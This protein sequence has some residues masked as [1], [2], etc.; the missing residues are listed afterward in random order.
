MI[1][2]SATFRWKTKQT[3]W[4]DP[5]I[6]FKNS[7]ERSLPASYKNIKCMSIAFQIFPLD[8]HI[9]GPLARCTRGLAEVR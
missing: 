9:V 5:L 7:C 2:V 4:S 8:E 6:W 1:M 3:S